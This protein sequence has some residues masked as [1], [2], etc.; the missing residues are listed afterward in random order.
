M[1][2]RT[3]YSRMQ[4]RAQFRASSF[5]KVKNA[6]SRFH[7]YAI[8]WYKQRR[9]EGLNLHDQHLKRIEDSI[10]EQLEIILEGNYDEETGKGRKGVKNTWRE[11]GYNEEEIALLEEAWA[12]LAIK[13]KETYREDK[14]K[15]KALRKEAEE[16]R[17]SRLNAKN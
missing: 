15:A 4:R 13:D 8:Q 2:K 9:E 5:L 1:S 17:R 3:T 10:S 11:I 16:K 12:S 7:P 6:Y 14:K